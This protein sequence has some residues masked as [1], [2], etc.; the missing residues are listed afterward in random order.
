[1]FINLGN[2]WNYIQLYIAL[3]LTRLGLFRVQNSMKV[4]QQHIHQQQQQQQAKQN[5]LVVKILLSHA[6]DVM[7]KLGIGHKEVIYAKALNV[8]LNR[9]AIPH[10]IEVDIP[11]MYMG[12]SVGHGR[13]DLI[14]DNLI[15]EIK[16]LAK[17][18]KEAMAQLHKYII[19]LS[20][21][22]ER[23]YR[24]VIVNFCQSSGDVVLYSHEDIPVQSF[25]AP[26]SGVL[27]LE[28]GSAKKPGKTRG[29]PPKSL[30]QSIDR[31][32]IDDPIQPPPLKKI[33]KS[34]FFPAIPKG[35]W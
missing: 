13:A 3:M 5:E 20:K 16:A 1:M 33:T 10:R 17:T 21:L 26:G 9:Y 14:I 22:E 15:V 11:I 6:Q 23:E 2:I 12:Q 35:V 18:P 34:R 24:G 28:N 32:D 8:S 19:N 30:A 25:P 29:R 4:S 7:K 27:M 31:M